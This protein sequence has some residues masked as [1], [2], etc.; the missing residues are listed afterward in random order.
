MQIY[1]N[2]NDLRNDKSD[3]RTHL[4]IDFLID[5]IGTSSKNIRNL[6]VIKKNS[7]TFSNIEKLA[8]ND[9]Y[10][11]NE[12]VYNNVKRKPYLDL[13]TV[14][15]SKK[16]FNMNFEKII[17]KLQLDIIKVFAEQYKIKI[18]KSDILLADSSG[19]VATGY[20]I[21]LHIVVA[22]KDKTY[23]YMNSKYTESSAFHLY[24]SLSALHASYTKILNSICNIMHIFLSH[25]IISKYFSHIKT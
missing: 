4:C 1:Y 9:K 11:V 13:E 3:K 8:F 12:I 17:K 15:E 20:K 18:T 19:K 7:K 25:N 14:Y 21:S 23:Y 22:P 6:T 5:K 2:R 10:Y 16:I 24:T